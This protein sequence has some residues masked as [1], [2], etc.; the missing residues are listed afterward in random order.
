MPAS[1]SI[2]PH[3]RL[4]PLVWRWLFSI[5]LL[6]LLLIVFPPFHIVS[7]RTV[8]ALA[9]RADAPETFAPAVFAARFWKERLQ[10]AASHAP[11]AAPLLAALRQDAAA[12]AKTHAHRVGLGSAAYYFV[13]G[14]GRVVGVERS[15]VLLEVDGAVIA[16]RK[17]PV[18]GNVVRDGCGLLDV[19]QVPGLGEF[20]ALS[21]ELNRLVETRVQPPLQSVAVGAT[22]RFS[23]CAEAPE[24]LPPPN[25]PWLNFI[26]LQAEVLP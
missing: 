9:A 25:S 19:N 17:G 21:A 12:A 15:R 22:L 16:L 14:T 4:T 5:G 2:A 3:H 6:T 23:G 1:P 8:T 13:R 18:F 10:P 26:P 7:R 20:N 11:P 24:T